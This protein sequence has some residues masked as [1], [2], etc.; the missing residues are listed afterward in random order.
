MEVYEVT[1]ETSKTETTIITKYKT[2]KYNTRWLVTTF[3]PPNCKL[4][5]ILYKNPTRKNSQYQWN[6]KLYIYTVCTK[7]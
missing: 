6:I 7:S 2:S 3:P 1:A 5:Y 4:Y